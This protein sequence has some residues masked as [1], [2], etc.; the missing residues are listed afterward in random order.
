[1]EQLEALSVDGGDVG[2]PFTY[3]E[4]KKDFDEYFCFGFI[5]GCL[6]SQARPLQSINGTN[7]MIKKNI[8]QKWRFGLRKALL[9]YDKIAP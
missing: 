8:L 9:N 2:N 6:H 1:M 4:M 3:D 7:V 5:M